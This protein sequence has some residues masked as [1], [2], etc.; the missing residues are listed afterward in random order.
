MIV[1][2]PDLSA[3]ESLGQRIAAKLQ[4][5][6]VVALTG[7]LGAGKTTLARS[8]IAAL[9][10]AGEVPSPTFTIVETYDPPSVRL[11]L[12]HADFYRLEDPSE[13]EEIGLDDYREGAALIAEWPDHAGGFAHEPSC[14]SIT[15]EI[16]GKGRKAIVEAGANWQSRIP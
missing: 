15:L 11:P 16:S 1:D 2:L 10:H 9:G 12:V 7:G 3:M 14:L 5:G 13:A 6:D 4:P 8:I